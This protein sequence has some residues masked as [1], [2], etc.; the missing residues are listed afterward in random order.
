MEGE[1]TLQV[2]LHYRGCNYFN[3]MDNAIDEL[4]HYFVHWNRRKPVAEQ[5]IPRISGEETE[6]GIRISM[7]RPDEERAWVWHYHMPGILQMN[8]SDTDQSVHWRVPVD[9]ETHLIPTTTFVPTGSEPR[10]RSAD[11]DPAEASRKIAEVAEE[12]RAGRLTIDDIELGGSYF[13][14]GDE[15]TQVG[16][17]LIADRQQERLGSSDAALILFR[18]LWRRELR[19]L[20]E[21]RPLTRWTQPSE[22]LL[23]TPRFEPIVGVAG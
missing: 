6:Y 11:E 2:T 14:I 9:D 20:A 18:N 17:G 16:Q 15:V 7:Q 12:I 3:N 21:G 8:T 1:G 10:R 5:V 23:A 22:P 19:A 4:H 13:P